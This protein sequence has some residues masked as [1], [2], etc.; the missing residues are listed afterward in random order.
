MYLSWYI[1][2]CLSTLLIVPPL[3][4]HLDVSSF[5]SICVIYVVSMLEA[6]VNYSS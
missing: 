4:A 5:I 1:I 3:K 6:M 2:L